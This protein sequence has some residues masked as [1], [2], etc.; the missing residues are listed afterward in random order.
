MNRGIYLT[1][2]SCPY[3][4]AARRVDLLSHTRTTEA[5]R[6]EKVLRKSQSAHEVRSLAPSCPSPLRAR[7]IRL[8]N[9]Y[10]VSLDTKLARKGAGERPGRRRLPQR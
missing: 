8:S 4:P 2:S 7:A 5:A 9:L 10:G 6:I 3:L 1:L